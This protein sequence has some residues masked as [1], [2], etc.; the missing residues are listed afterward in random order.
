MLWDYRLARQTFKNIKR[1]PKKERE[2]IFTVLEEMK[3][4]PFSGDIK[5]I[6]GEE[7]LYRRRI[8]NYRI[9]FRPIKLQH[10]FDISLIE[11]KQSH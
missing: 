5:L 6:Q 1:F 7:N 8:G 9:Y 10:I 2:K 3:T 11:R 4:G